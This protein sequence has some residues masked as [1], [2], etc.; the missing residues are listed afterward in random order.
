MRNNTSQSQFIICSTEYFDR[1]Q[2]IHLNVF[3]QSNEF[4]L[5]LLTMND[6]AIICEHLRIKFEYS[7]LSLC[8]YCWNE[9]IVSYVHIVLCLTCA[10]VHIEKLRY[11]YSRYLFS[12][13]VRYTSV[14]WRAR[15]EHRTIA[16]HVLIHRLH[17]VVHARLSISLCARAHVHFGHPSNA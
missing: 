10:F 11:F 3:P 8:S 4:Q 14:H 16:T 13:V 7:S 5:L 6:R 9:H 15:H 1:L 17:S 2:F 12:Y